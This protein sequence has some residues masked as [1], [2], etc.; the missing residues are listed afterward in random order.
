MH[1][2][3][4]ASLFAFVLVISLCCTKTPHETPAPVIHNFTV[5]Q[6]NVPWT[7]Q[8]A[9]ALYFS[10]GF[11]DLHINATATNGDEIY[12]GLY[13][14]SLNPLKSYPLVL[15]GVNS[16]RVMTSS[17]GFTDCDVP[18][19]GG[20]VRLTKF[21]TV[22]KKISGDFAFT[23]FDKDRNRLDTF[24]NGLFTDI[25]LDTNNVRYEGSIVTATLNKYKLVFKNCLLSIWEPGLHK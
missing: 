11:T 1:Q 21:D 2:I 15:D 8:D 13:V 9:S 7:F 25:S 20:Y 22:N 3:R 19:T 6:N 10:A 12:I 14:D 24:S 5:K 16:A 18:N 4:I 17:K 23:T